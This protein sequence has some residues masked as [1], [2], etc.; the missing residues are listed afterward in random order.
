MTQYAV[1]RYWHQTG[2]MAVGSKQA[3]TKILRTGKAGK[4]V[5]K[6]VAG[7]VGRKHYGHGLYLQI[8]ESGSASWLLRYQRNG[9]ETWMGLGPKSVFTVKQ[10]RARARAA[11]QQIYDGIDPLLARRE[12]RALQALQDARSVTFQSAAEQYYQQHERKWSSAKH[13]QAFVNTLQEYAYPVIGKL[14]VAAV[15]TAAV[16]RIV[17]PIWIAK[18]PTASRVRGRIEAVLDW[19][20]VRGFRAGDNPARGQG[21]LDQVLPS[22]GDIAK[23]VHH[24][25]LPYADVPGFVTP[26][27]QHQGIGPKALEFIIL[28]A[29]RTSEVTKASWSEF[30]FGQEVWFIPGERMKSRK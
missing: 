5:P 8:G 17:E 20:T 24:I 6:T 26:L 7:T 21:H 1:S 13:R 30:D 29:A 28:T 10:A 3:K 23:P 18:N 22:G 4:A 9:K 19:S 2:G 12:Q 14:P 15:D 27:A 16:L 11:Q 25:A